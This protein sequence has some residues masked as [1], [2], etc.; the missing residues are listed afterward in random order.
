MVETVIQVKLVDDDKHE[1]YVKG[2]VDVSRT[3]VTAI[4]LFVENIHG[5]QK[6]FKIHNDAV[7]K[8]FLMIDSRTTIRSSTPS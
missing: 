8:H 1:R 7:T 6:N 5:H 2:L 3:N 4:R